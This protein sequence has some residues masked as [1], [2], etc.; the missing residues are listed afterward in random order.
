MIQAIVDALKPYLRPSTVTFFVLVLA[1][2]V[3]LAFGRRTQRFARWYFAAALAG[4]WIA[5]AP[6]CAERLIE[7]EAA[8]FR[9][10]TSAWNPRSASS[11]RKPGMSSSGRGGRSTWLVKIHF[12][13]SAKT[14]FLSL[15]GGNF[16]E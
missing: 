12:R 15:H 10:E 8:K 3:A 13:G 9:V 2:G 11:C 1:V 6:A 7:R 16:A 14:Q 5:S 4:F